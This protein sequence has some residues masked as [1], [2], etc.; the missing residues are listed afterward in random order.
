MDILFI[1][2]LVDG[3]SGCFTF[4]AIM[5]N[6]SMNIYLQVSLW[7]YIFIFLGYILWSG[8]AALCGN[9]VFNH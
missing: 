7:T 6:V 3:Y 8:I 1:Q 2:S 4:L 9:S 5:N